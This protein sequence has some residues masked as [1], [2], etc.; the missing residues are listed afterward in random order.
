MKDV[1]PPNRVQ[2]EPR[3]QFTEACCMQDKLAA[4]VLGEFVRV[5]VAIQTTKTGLPKALDQQPVQ[6]AAKARPHR[7]NS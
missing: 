2:R 1:G 4:Q 5:Y 6:E 3:K 7:V